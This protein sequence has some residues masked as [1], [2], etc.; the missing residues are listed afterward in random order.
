LYL[1]FY[2]KKSVKTFD[3]GSEKEYENVR[4]YVSYY[5]MD[6]QQRLEERPELIDIKQVPLVERT[7]KK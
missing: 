7:E 4:A 6:L 5:D 3:D 1:S 2:V